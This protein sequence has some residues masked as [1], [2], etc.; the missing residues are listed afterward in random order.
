VDI[1]SEYE[2]VRPLFINTA[3]ESELIR[4]RYESMQERIE[5]LK[6]Y[7]LKKHKVDVAMRGR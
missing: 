5:E 2:S 1:D 6:R 3:V 4:K 7:L